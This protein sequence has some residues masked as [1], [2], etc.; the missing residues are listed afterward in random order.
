MPALLSLFY[1]FH[2]Q[3]LK[4]FLLRYQK[5]CCLILALC[6]H[7]GLSACHTNP[8]NAQKAVVNEA[9]SNSQRMKS[10][11]SSSAIQEFGL[12]K[13]AEDSGY[14]FFTLYIEFPERGFAEYFTVNIE[15]MENMNAE[16]LTNAVGKYISFEYNSDIVNALIE[17]EYNDKGIILQ[18]DTVFQNDDLKRITGVL[19]NAAE[20]TQGDLPA[21]IFVTSEEEITEKFS[22][23]I[24][25]DIVA[26]NGKVV[27][28][29]Y[30]QRTLN[31]ITTMEIKE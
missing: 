10:N 26:V 12:L 8:N 20:E 27:T 11:E 2:P 6:F 28:A 30:E 9:L 22:F 31:T 17:I 3:I 5:R 4:M 29:H 19:S 15:N 13:S 21:E 1:Y 7:L 16:D 24:T 25:A 18:D 23:F 14:P